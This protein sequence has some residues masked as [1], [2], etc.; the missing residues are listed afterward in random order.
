MAMVT[1]LS[2]MSCESLGK[3]GLVMSDPA[4]SDILVLM[5]FDKQSQRCISEEEQIATT[6]AT[7][8]E[9]LSSSCINGSSEARY[10]RHNSI[11]FLAEALAISFHVGSA[12]GKSISI[13]A[14]D[15][16]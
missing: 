2:M 16:T 8:N 7:V 14:K 15:R 11:A 9:C 4:A 6:Q 12:A 1:I 10:A 3:S 13:L 5:M